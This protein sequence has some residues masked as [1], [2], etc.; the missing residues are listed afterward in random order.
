MRVLLL[1]ARTP[2]DPMKEHEHESFV[3]H[4]GLPSEHIETFDLHQGSPT[5]EYVRSFDALMVGG[6]GEYYVSKRN[7]PEFERLLDLLRQVVD[8]GHPTYASCFGYQCLML[9]LG[10]EVIFDPGRTEVGTYEIEL[11]GEG[12]ADELFGMLPPTFP[13]QLGHKDRATVEPPGTRNL[14]SSDRCPLQALRV[15]GKPIWA[16]QFHPELDRERNLQRFQHYVDGYAA[17]LPPAEFEE[18]VRSFR[19]SPDASRLLARFLD[20]VFG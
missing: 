4:T 19:D 14:A 9:A 5:W 12:R 3:F 11:T 17:H 16:S 8:A 2:E 15:P 20:L 1:R 18:K 13:A 6:A 10:G 7:V